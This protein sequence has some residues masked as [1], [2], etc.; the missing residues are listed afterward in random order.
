MNSRPALAWLAAQEH[1][2]IVVTIGTAMQDAR[3]KVT[4]VEAKLQ[5]SINDAH[6]SDG[7]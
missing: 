6:H 3:P 1:G 4:D 2:A 7:S 5:A